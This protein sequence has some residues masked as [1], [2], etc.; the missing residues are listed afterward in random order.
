MIVRHVF[1]CNV[2]TESAKRLRENFI[3]EVLT[4]T[5]KTIP[6]RKNTSNQVLASAYRRNN[7]LVCI[8]SGVRFR[9]SFITRKIKVRQIFFREV[10]NSDYWRSWQF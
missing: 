6:R 5:L 3:F 2:L 9:V 1:W 8:L 7:V 10:R 4:T